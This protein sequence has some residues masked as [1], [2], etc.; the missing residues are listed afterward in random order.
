MSLWHS[1]SLGWRLNFLLSSRQPENAPR[2]KIC[3]CISAFLGTRKQAEFIIWDMELS[4]CKNQFSKRL[5]SAETP[6]RERE[7]DRLAAEKP[8]NSLAKDG[9]QCTG[10]AFCWMQQ[11]VLWVTVDSHKTA[12]SKIIL[13]SSVWQASQPHKMP[14]SILFPGG[15][16]PSQQSDRRVKQNFYF[17]NACQT[18]LPADCGRLSF[19]LCRSTLPGAFC[20]LAGYLY[21]LSGQAPKATHNCNTKKCSST[22]WGQNKTTKHT[23]STEEGG[24]TDSSKVSNITCLY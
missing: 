21:S 22:Y 3:L 8:F 5:L 15:H 1:G 20:V 12:K 9:N 10:D 18:S 23:G 6:R 16:I 11:I 7:R 19:N 14:V 4:N 13:K 2:A 17:R 24:W